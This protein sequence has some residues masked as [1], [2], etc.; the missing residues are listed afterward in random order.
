MLFK[1]P[2]R[3]FA[4]LVFLFLLIVQVVGAP[5][6]G[7]KAKLAQVN[8][9]AQRKQ[10]LLKS[11]QAGAISAHS[12][13]KNAHIRAHISNVAAAAKHE[14]VRHDPVNNAAEHGQAAQRHREMAQTHLTAAVGHASVAKSLRTDSRPHLWSKVAQ[15]VESKKAA[16]ESHKAQLDHRPALLSSKFMSTAYELQKA[17]HMQQ[18]ASKRA[19]QAGYNGASLLHSV[20]SGRQVEMADAYREKAL[21]SSTFNPPESDVSSVRAELAGAHLIAAHARHWQGHALTSMQ[22]SHDRI[23]EAALQA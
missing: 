10:H 23:A 14:P 12:S 5:A 6:K 7:R 4:A 16:K 13:V 8:K 1:Q 18:I 20:N 3:A 19:S 11:A 17:A 2:C 15:F 22:R 21:I 9:A